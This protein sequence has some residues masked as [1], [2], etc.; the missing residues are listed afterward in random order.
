M[1]ILQ[2][3]DLLSPIFYRQDARLLLRLVINLAKPLSARGQ[4]DQI[5]AGGWY[6]I[7]LPHYGEPSQV[8]VGENFSGEVTKKYRSGL[9]FVLWSLNTWHQCEF[10]ITIVTTI[11]AFLSAL[12]Y[13]MVRLDRQVQQ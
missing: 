2:F 1:N 10:S 6:S 9:A 5:K 11:S 3:H 12:V 7:R 13:C 8:D 4:V